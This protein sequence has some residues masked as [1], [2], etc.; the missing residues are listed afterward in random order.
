MFRKKLAIRIA[1]FALCFVTMFSIGA[2]GALAAN[3]CKAIYKIT[4][5]EASIEVSTTKKWRFSSDRVVIKQT[6]GTVVYNNHSCKDKTHKVYAVYDVTCKNLDTGKVT[7]ATLTGSSIKL[8]LERD[9][10]YR[11][12]LTRRGPSVSTWQD[13]M[14]GWFQYWEKDTSWSVSSTRGITTC[15][16]SY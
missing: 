6:K 15:G 13:I 9:T 16:M 3:A 4:D 11:I 2:T 1:A 14:W 12:T 7:K 8:K 5:E 10:D